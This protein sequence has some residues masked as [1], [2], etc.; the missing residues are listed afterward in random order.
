MVMT[1]MMVNLIL[2]LTHGDLN[3]LY[4]KG[5]GLFVTTV[6]VGVV[7][8]NAPYDLKQRPY[9]RDIVFNLGALASIAI[10]VYRKEINLL[11]AV[12]TEIINVDLFL[13]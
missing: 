8:F 12:G 6:V 4:F 5:A 1:M 9:L 10:I 11:Q 3:C 2:F 13:I 7:S